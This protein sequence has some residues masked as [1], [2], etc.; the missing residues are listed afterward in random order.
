MA[1]HVPCPD[2]WTRAKSRYI[3]D[4]THAEKQF[5]MQASPE[6]IFYDASAAQKRHEAS[7]TSRRL[8]NKLQPLIT[9][10]EQYGQALDVYSNASPLVLGPLWG[11]IRILLLV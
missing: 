9:A 7:S 3:E 10:I 5:Y 1:S 4:L 8:I 11:S 2:A 6:T